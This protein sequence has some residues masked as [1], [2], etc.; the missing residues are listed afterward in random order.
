MKKAVFLFTILAIVSIATSYGQENITVKGQVIDNFYT[1]IYLDN[2]LAETEVAQAFIDE[3][4]NYELKGE[5]EETDYFKLRLDDDT[6]M[7][8]VI[9]PGENVTVQFN[10]DEPESSKITGSP[11]SVLYQKTNEGIKEIDERIAKEKND[12]YV[13]MIEKNPTS[14]TCVIYAGELDM[15]EFIETHRKLADG[16]RNIDNSYAQD[17]VMGVDA[18]AKTG[19][20]AVASEINQ[21]TP[22][23]DF[24]KL[25]SLK[26]Q[27]VLVDFWAAWCRPCR[28][29]SP[30]L[31]SAYNKYNKDGFTIYSVSLD[32]AKSDWTDAIKKDGMGAWTHV[33]D[34]KGWSCE[35][36][37]EYGVSSIPANFLLD[38]DG[39]IIAKDLRGAA[40]EAKLKELFGH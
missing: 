36:A 37:G 14:I 5:I 35:P 15:E 11:S 4:G 16:I 17:Y 9:E 6:Y 27:Y 10:I 3:N 39:K 31:V 26:G 20:G 12:Y 19:I 33:S 2:I 8:L 40:L 29:E 34:L 30:T 28:G 38:K 21:P 32:E 25:S 7:L 1:K 24:V 13:K 23:G 22:D 18:Y